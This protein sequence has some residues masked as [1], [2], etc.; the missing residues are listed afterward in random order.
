MVRLYFFAEYLSMTSISA[1]PVDST[2]ISVTW[3]S[4]DKTL[5]GFYYYYLNYSF[6]GLVYA[7][8]TTINYSVTSGQQTLMNLL[9][10]TYYSISVRMCRNQNGLSNCSDPKT[11]APVKT[12]CG[13][14]PT[15]PL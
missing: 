9:P 13:G 14:R 7:S 12:P 10:D 8:N 2:S 6:D 15:R 4:N 5:N 1:E 11:A 3:I